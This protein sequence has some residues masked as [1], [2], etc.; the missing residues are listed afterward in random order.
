M[1]EDLITED[2]IG[3]SEFVKK[4]GGTLLYLDNDR[5]YVSC[6]KDHRFYLTLKGLEKGDWCLRCFESLGEKKIAK[7]LDEREI[8]YYRECKFPNL[9]HLAQLRVDFFLP[10]LNLI[11]EYDGIGHILPRCIGNKS[12]E[13]K[14][15]K[16]W[17][18]FYETLKRDQIKN[19]WCKRNKRSLLRIYYWDMDNL[20]I[21]L[22][23]N[24]N[25]NCNFVLIDECESWRIRTLRELKQNKRP[26]TSPSRVVS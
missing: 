9:C 11:I 21:I 7:Y 8:R 6:H 20:E 23:N 5:V 2:D 15:T 26:T 13:E 22:A 3:Y 16:L 1:M 24:L 25:Y 17:Y 4:R 14:N 12:D 10:D 19:E 18:R